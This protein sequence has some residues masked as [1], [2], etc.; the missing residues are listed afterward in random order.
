M[1]FLK[2]AGVASMIALTSWAVPL[3]ASVWHVWA[4]AVDDLDT[5]V[6]AAGR[7]V[8]NAVWR[9]RRVQLTLAGGDVVACQIVLEGDEAGAFQVVTR[10]PELWLDHGSAAI[11]PASHTG[12]APGRSGYGTRIS[13]LTEPARA[14]RG[15]AESTGDVVATLP[16][17]GRLRLR[18]EVRVPTDQPP[19][20]YRGGL[21]VDA[22]RQRVLVPIDLRV[23]PRE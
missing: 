15:G 2:R 3:Q 20:L 16:R 13:L 19:G 12:E 18:L 23:L 4:T 14:V 9:D 21:I 7:Q 5:S 1:S 11:G 8:Q 17:R 22:D 10:G 6:L